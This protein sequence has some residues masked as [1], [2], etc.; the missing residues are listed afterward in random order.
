[1]VKRF[2]YK[3]SDATQKV[4]SIQTRLAR[5]RALVA[6]LEAEERGYKAFLLDYYDPGKT[7]VEFPENRTL[8]VLLSEFEM[9]VLDQEKAKRLILRAGKRIPYMRVSVTKLKVSKRK[10]K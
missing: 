10:G 2:T 3:A 7:L 6:R 1:M 5:A 9:E 8:E 4:F